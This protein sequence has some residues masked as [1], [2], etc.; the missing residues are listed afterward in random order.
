MLEVGKNWEFENQFTN[1]K[2]ITTTLATE[3]TTI[4]TE[5]CPQN[6][7]VCRNGGQCLILNKSDIFCVC[8]NDFSGNNFINGKYKNNFYIRL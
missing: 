7:K 4:D 6:T 5:L 8:T 3:T 2:T 1:I